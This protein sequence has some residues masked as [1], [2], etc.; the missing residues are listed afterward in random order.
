MKSACG[1]SQ[2]FV[3]VNVFKRHIDVN[4]D[5]PVVCICG[6]FGCRVDK[7]ITVKHKELTVLPG[8]SLEH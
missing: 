1:E 3:V 7:E 2:L 5:M 8:F 6:V 4:L